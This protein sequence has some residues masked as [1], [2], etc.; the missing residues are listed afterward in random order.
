MERTRARIFIEKLLSADGPEES[1][2]R[3]RGRGENS[4]AALRAVQVRV[5]SAASTYHARELAEEGE[6]DG[7][8][9]V[10]RVPLDGDQPPAPVRLDRLGEAVRGDARDA[11]ALA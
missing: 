2:S 6:R 9:Q 8:G 5:S 4:G 10:L 11:Q 3:T 7:V 1:G